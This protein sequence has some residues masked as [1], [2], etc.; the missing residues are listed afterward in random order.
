M[1]HNY[2]NLTDI[3]RHHAYGYKTGKYCDDNAR[4]KRRKKDWMGAAVYRFVGS[5]TST[6]NTQLS[7]T[8]MATKAKPTKMDIS[9]IVIWLDI[10]IQMFILRCQWEKLYQQGSVGVGMGSYVGVPGIITRIL[11]SM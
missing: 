1:C 3:S 8:R 5:G 4:D 11:K 2:K 10:S 6:N 7:I 9:A